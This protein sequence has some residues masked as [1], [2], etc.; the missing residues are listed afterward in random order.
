MDELIDTFGHGSFSGHLL[1]GG[2]G[3]NLTPYTRL[4]S[5]QSQS[6]AFPLHPFSLFLTSVSYT[7]KTMRRQMKGQSHRLHMKMYFSGVNGPVIYCHTSS[8]RFCGCVRVKT[9][10]RS[11]IGLII[12]S[13][14][15]DNW[16]GIHEGR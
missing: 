10:Q 6:T 9:F 14:V 5:S 12:E 8:A 15:T 2:G 13:E 16:P 11:L 7:A 1:L 3:D 4:C